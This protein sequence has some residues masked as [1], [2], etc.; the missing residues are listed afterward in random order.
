MNQSHH[1]KTAHTEDPTDREKMRSYNRRMNDKKG[2]LIHIKIICDKGEVM[3]KI[4]KNAKL[5]SCFEIELFCFDC[6]EM[7][8][9]YLRG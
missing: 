9:L 7:A 8:C 3:M 5:A 1:S 4:G 2:V 6:I